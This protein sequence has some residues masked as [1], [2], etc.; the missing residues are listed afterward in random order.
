MGKTV[1]VTRHEGA[2]KW[3]RAKGF[4]GEVVAHI[5]EKDIESLKPGDIVIGVLP[6]QL[7]AEILSRGAE[8]ILL[9]L[10]A[11]AFSDRGKELSPEEM[12][13]AGAK[14]YRVKSVQLEEVS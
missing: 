7:I 1:I 13:K 12:D 2:I 14:L 5:T 10:P 4:D 9:S 3:I 11:V 6:L 8:F